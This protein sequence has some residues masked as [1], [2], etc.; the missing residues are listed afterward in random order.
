MAAVAVRNLDDQTH[1]RLKEMA[2]R[3]GHSLEAEIRR[4]LDKAAGLP[5][6]NIGMAFYRF[7]QEHGGF[8]L[9]IPEREFEDPD[10]SLFA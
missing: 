6:E 8:E 2:A 3:H 10:E 7:A 5:D 1:A 9:D 4:I